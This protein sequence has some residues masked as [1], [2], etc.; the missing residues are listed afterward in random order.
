[1]DEPSAAG[2]SGVAQQLE[3]GPLRRELGV[4]PDTPVPP[5][6]P[7]RHSEHLHFS[8]R[9]SEY[10]RI[11]VVNLLL[12][13]ATLGVYS[14]WAKVR[15]ARWFARHTA[16]GGHRFDF[17]GEPWRI[18][19]GRAIA[20]A[21][22]VLWSFAFDVSAWFGLAVLALFCV[23]GPLLFAGA[24]RFRLANT[25]WRGLRF[26][27]E[28]PRREVFVVCVPLVLMWTVGTVFQA[29][30]VEGGWLVA[31]GLLTLFGFPWA[32][33]RLKQM[34]HSHAAYGNVRFA[35][36]H[37]TASFY[38]L[39]AKAAVLAFVGGAFAVPLLGLLG[40]TAGGGAAQPAWWMAALFGAVVVLATWLVAWP[41]FAARLQQV[42][43]GATHCGPLR[44]RGEMKGFVL[45]RLVIVQTLLV[46]A[47]C[48][49]YW[50]FA[51]VAIARYRVQSIV[52]E[53]DAPLP[54]VE[55]P[56]VPEGARRAAG[57]AAADFFGLDIGW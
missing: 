10:F 56:A 33:A 16:L 52:V 42:V 55:A 50:P 47:T 20:V 1:M 2:G 31:A 30:G 36:G 37:A 41:Y 57:D 23:V 18:L 12:T 40:Q 8:G 39:Y 3:D 53:S 11:W 9:G 7:A 27:F 34:Q 49:L 28:A 14:A 24:Q 25:S 29:F 17:H 4:A 32:H 54:D 44:F 13:L 45:W 21:L 6:P 38:G 22:L 26:S 19:L 51:A 35:Y 15:K 48:G 5:A 43:W 46:L